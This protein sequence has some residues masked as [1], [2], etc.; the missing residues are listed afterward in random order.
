MSGSCPACLYVM[1]T[2]ETQNYWLV[3]T[4]GEIIEFDGCG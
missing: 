2:I 3:Y 1:R 4:D